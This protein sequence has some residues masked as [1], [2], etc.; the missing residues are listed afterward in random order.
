MAGSHLA[1]R[2]HSFDHRAQHHGLLS[3]NVDSKVDFCNFTD[4]WIGLCGAGAARSRR[5]DN[6]PCG[7]NHGKSI[8]QKPFFILVRLVSIRVLYHACR[9][10]VFILLTQPRCRA[11][12]GEG[13]LLEKHTF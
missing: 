4:M 7:K 13:V 1:L 11:G 5:G 2:T 10:R 9:G 12:T 3:Q 8:M 6:G